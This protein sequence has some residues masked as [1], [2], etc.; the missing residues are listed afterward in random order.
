MAINITEAY[1]DAL[2][3]KSEESKRLS[4][5]RSLDEYFEKQV[6]TQKAMEQLERG[7][8]VPP[9]IAKLVDVEA[10]KKQIES[11]KTGENKD[12]LASNIGGGR[13][14]QDKLDISGKLPD[15]DPAESYAKCCQQATMNAHVNA[16][17]DQKI[18]ELAEKYGIEKSAVKDFFNKKAIDSSNISTPENAESLYNPLVKS[19]S[20]QKTPYD[21]SFTDDFSGKEVTLSLSPEN[22]LKLQERFGSLE[23]AGDFVK[24]WYNDAAYNVGYLT[25]DTDKDGIISMEEAVNI[26][27]MVDIN[28]G[29]NSYSSIADAI[30]DP[31]KQR[32]FLEKFGYADNITDFINHSISQD[33][34]LDGALSNAEILGE[35]KFAVADVAF[36]G[37]KMDIFTFNSMLF[38]RSINDREN[39]ALFAQR[40]SEEIADSLISSKEEEQKV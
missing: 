9:E 31:S 38:E 24:S 5:P 10:L 40:A 7:G 21:V 1:Y 26:N 39:I 16:A 25:Q 23:K 14:I 30:E 11:A 35:Q 36:S 2:Y 17:E 8:S 4:S 22:A 20:Y 18:S 32:E 28:K 37:E 34:N 6:A 27:S 15:L 3:N 19:A 13:G 12:S 33:K 29:E